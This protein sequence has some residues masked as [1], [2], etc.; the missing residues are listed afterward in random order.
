MALEVFGL[1]LIQGVLL[2]GLV[3][4]GG[5]VPSSVLVASANILCLVAA[6]FRDDYNEKLFNYNLPAE[7][8][9]VIREG[10]GG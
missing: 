6:W 9:R 2:R 4:V 10:Q 8:E 3:G 1:R 5:F 7:V